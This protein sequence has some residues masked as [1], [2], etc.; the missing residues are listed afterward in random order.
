MDFLESEAEV[1]ASSQA[2]LVV[3][4]YPIRYTI[5]SNY[6]QDFPKQTTGLHLAA[7]FGVEEAMNALLKKSV[8]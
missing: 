1:E 4:P 8:S 6:S 7:Y 3:E 5:R 2:L